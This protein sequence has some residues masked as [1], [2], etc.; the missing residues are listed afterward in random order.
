M[1]ARTPRV[2]T[3]SR[4]QPLPAA[5]VPCNYEGPDKRELLIE[6]A[7]LARRLFLEGKVTADAVIKAG[8]DLLNHIADET[9]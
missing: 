3:G 7:E 4:S 9:E 6:R 8:F 1:P 5:Y 2:P